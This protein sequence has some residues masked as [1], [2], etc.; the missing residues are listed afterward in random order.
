LAGSTSDSGPYIWGGFDAMKF[1]LFKHNENP[2][3]G[4]R[5]M[6]ASAS[7]FVPEVEQELCFGRFRKRIE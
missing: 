4:S 7:G 1:N 3:Q 5:P 6:S 2:E